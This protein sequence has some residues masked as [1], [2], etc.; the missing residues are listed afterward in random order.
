MLGGPA[1]I[2][3]GVARRNQ[4]ENHVEISKTVETPEEKKAKAEI[5]IILLK[6][7]SVIF[8]L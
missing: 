7:T 1:T 5:L 4:K 6:A 2:E 3:D 8:L